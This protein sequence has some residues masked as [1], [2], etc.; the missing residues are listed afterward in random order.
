SRFFARP[1]D[2]DSDS[3]SDSSTEE[4]LSSSEEEEELL[5]SSDEDEDEDQSDDEQGDDNESDDDD[6]PANAKN[7]FFKKGSTLKSDSESDSDDDNKGVVVKSAREKLIADIQETADK[8]ADIQISNDLDFLSLLDLFSRLTNFLS[9]AKQLNLSIP[10]AY[11]STLVELDY[12]ISDQQQ[13]N[14]IKKLNASQTKAFNILKQ[15]VRRSTKEDD[16]QELIKLFKENPDGFEEAANSLESQRNVPIAPVST[17]K[18][19][20]IADKADIF[21]TLE[22]VAE[23]RGKKNV[24]RY[25]QISILESVIPDATTP[26]QSIL[27]YLML[28]PLR[29][30]T[31]LNSS[32]MPL[33]QWNKAEKDISDLFTI[34]EKNSSKYR[35]FETAKPQVDPYVEPTPSV[36]G[37]IEIIGS[38]GSF[39]E[40]LD[41]ELTRSLQTIDPHST[42]YIDRLKDEL[43]IY[44]LIL[45]AQLY[46]ELINENHPEDTQFARVILRRI[47]HIYYKPIQLISYT[48]KVSWEGTTKSSKI[49]PYSKNLDSYGKAYANTLMDSLC[50]VLYTQSN[51]VFRKKAMLSHIYYYSFNDQ[52]YKARDMLLMS[53]LQSTIHTS[54]PILKVLFNRSLVQLG[55][56][57]F[58]TGLIAESFEILNEIATSSNQKELLGQNTSRYTQHQ[59]NSAERQRSLPFHMH[60]N[61]ELLDCVFLTCSLLV[62]IPQMTQVIDSK[63]KPPSK[64]LKKLLEYNERQYFQGPPENTKES[65]THAAKALQQGDWQKSYNF[66]NEVKI[67]SL[68]TNSDEIKQMI[69]SKLQIEALRTYIFQFKKYYDKLSIEKLAARFS[70]K[71]N[72]IISIVSKMIFNEEI[73]AALDQKNGSISFNKSYELTKLQQLSLLLAEKAGSLAEKNERL[74]AGGHQQNQ[75]N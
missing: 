57:A 50:S 3:D 8:I 70:L 34:L 54:E 52:Y 13:D 73:D 62:E 58:R 36:D 27:T 32:S 10:P 44:K 51:A 75:G 33:E 18:T 67:W 49:T 64:S 7:D 60:I 40:R 66:I 2:S 14:S 37:F 4:L 22:S 23:L 25:D 68:F 20:A 5:D 42:E 45:R 55:M 65:I 35:V 48:E 26:F 28:V 71:E 41:D 31:S 17:L 43:K 74:A 63:K 30:D 6:K 1:Y 61:S 39:I 11:I 29:F 9:R 21:T 72:Q 59:F 38:I 15:R 16:F 69:Q 24:N 53:H 56:C 46:C 12:F 19:T 47:D